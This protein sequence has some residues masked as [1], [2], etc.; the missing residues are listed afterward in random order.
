MREAKTRDTSNLQEQSVVPY[1]VFLFFA[2]ER[3]INASLIARIFQKTRQERVAGAR[4]ET[5]EEK[6]EEKRKG[7]RRRREKK[8]KTA[9]GG[10]TIP[11]GSHL[12][13]SGIGNRHSSLFLCRASV[14]LHLSLFFLLES[15][16]APSL[17]RPFLFRCKKGRRRRRRKNRNSKQES[18]SHR[19]RVSIMFSL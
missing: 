5:C 10:R 3:A 11:R 12:A 7:R 8:G 15:P 16:R 18:P 17:F 2:K 4:S 1:I 19:V 6:G 9:A 13:V 14:F